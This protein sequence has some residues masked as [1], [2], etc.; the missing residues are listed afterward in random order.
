MKKPMHIFGQCECRRCRKA[1]EKEAAREQA[2]K[3][4]GLLLLAGFLFVFVLVPMTGGAGRP[5]RQAPEAAAITESALRL[6]VAQ[7]NLDLMVEFGELPEGSTF[8]TFMIADPEGY[9][10]FLRSVESEL[11]MAQ[12]NWRTNQ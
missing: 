5:E 7:R 11:D 2:R 4:T 1:V 8:R 3:A 6:E 12:L 10:D 9:A